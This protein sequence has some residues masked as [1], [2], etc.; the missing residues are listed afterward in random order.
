MP[1][2]FQ[3][4]LAEG[5]DSGRETHGLYDTKSNDKAYRR[6]WAEDVSAEFRRAMKRR[7]FFVYWQP[8]MEVRG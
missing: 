3:I 4:P 1:R 6:R 2:V 7:R 5:G 8:E